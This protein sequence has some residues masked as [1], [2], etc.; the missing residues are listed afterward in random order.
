L[1]E[2]K[3]LLPVFALRVAY[4]QAQGNQPIQLRNKN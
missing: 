3:K 2:V 4:K 1:E